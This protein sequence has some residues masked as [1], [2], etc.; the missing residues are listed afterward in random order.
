MRGPKKGPKDPS[1]L[2]TICCEAFGDYLS[3]AQAN[4]QP[5]TSLHY[6]MSIQYSWVERHPYLNSAFILISTA[7][8]RFGTE[9]YMVLMLL[10]WQ[11]LFT[12]CTAHHKFMHHAF[13]DTGYIRSAHMYEYI[14]VFIM[15]L[16]GIRHVY[17]SPHVY[18]MSLIALH[19]NSVFN[20]FQLKDSTLHTLNPSCYRVQWPQ[21]WWPA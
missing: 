2:K 10:H 15:S 4:Q 6:Y 16:C 3:C 20:A 8:W 19:Q 9:F 18:Y 21:H 7:E 11:N 12:E 13:H 14:Y 5:W 17:S 1:N